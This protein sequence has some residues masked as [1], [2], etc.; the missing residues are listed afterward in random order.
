MSTLPP[1]Q[2]PRSLKHNGAKTIC[3]LESVLSG[4]DMKLKNRHWYNLGPQYFR[5]DFNVKVIIGAADLQF[6]FR[7]KEDQPFSRQ[8]DA[9]T[10][11]WDPPREI[12]NGD[13]DDM[14]AMYRDH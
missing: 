5:A 8:H 4:V 13:A 6:Q 7:S 12:L 2:L 14:A 3:A 10:V 11:K 1:E 9:I